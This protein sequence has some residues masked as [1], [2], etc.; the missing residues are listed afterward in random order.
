MNKILLSRPIFYA[1]SEGNELLGP[2]NK[3]HR[4][5]LVTFTIDFESGIPG[6]VWVPQKLFLYNVFAKYVWGSV[7]E[8]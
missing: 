5:N 2:L 4:F 3:S 6:L 7:Q 1:Y 8:R